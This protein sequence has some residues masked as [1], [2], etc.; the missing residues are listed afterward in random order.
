MLRR[1]RHRRRSLL[2]LAYIATAIT[3]MIRKGRKS[4][5]SLYLDPAI[6]A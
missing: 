1:H 4:T 2:R 3:T 6:A 5:G